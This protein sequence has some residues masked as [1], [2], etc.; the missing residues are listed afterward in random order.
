MR[1]EEK[2]RKK[3][4]KYAIIFR[5]GPVLDLIANIA[6]KN[7]NKNALKILLSLLLL[8]RPQKVNPIH[9]NAQIVGVII[10]SKNAD[11]KGIADGVTLPGMMKLTAEKSKMANL[12]QTM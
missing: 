2:T 3:R 10:I 5:Q 4:T 9:L 12:K 1:G 6:T 11:T 7:L 8:P